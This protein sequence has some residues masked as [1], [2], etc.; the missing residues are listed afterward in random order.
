VKLIN[1]LIFQKYIDDKRL[2][3]NLVAQITN[4]TDIATLRLTFYVE[5][6]GLRNGW[7]VSATRS[8]RSTRSTVSE[9]V[10]A[11]VLFLTNGD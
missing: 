1:K 9:I 10:C 4:A 7:Q 3:M 6:P 2:V 5:T 8:P 11:T